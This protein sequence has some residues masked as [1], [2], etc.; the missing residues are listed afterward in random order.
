MSALRAPDLWSVLLFVKA[1]KTLG[2]RKTAFINTIRNTVDLGSEDII[3]DDGNGRR[4]DTK[5]RVIQG[6]RNTLGKTLSSFS[7]TGFTKRRERSDHPDDRSEQTHQGS[8]AGDRRDKYQVLFKHGQ[9]QRS[10][11][12]HLF[13]NSQ[14]L[15]FRI[16]LTGRDHFFVFAQTRF[17]YIP[18]TAFLLVA[19]SNS[20]IYI[21]VRQVILHLADKFGDIAIAGRFPDREKTLDHKSQ[22]SQ[23]GADQDRYDDPSLVH[24]GQT[25]LGALLLG[26]EPTGKIGLVKI[27]VRSDQ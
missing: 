1:G 15:L 19:L 17:H 23:K 9:F 7:T 2:Q 20:C 6:L 13:L 24:F 10:R 16:Q 11:F 5:G 3:H 27:A 22:Y 21:L 18:Y 26:P 14:Y 8:H 12:F 4:T 25:G